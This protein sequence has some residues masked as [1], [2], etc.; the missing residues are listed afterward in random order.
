MPTRHAAR[1]LAL[2]GWALASCSAAVGGADAGA[3][4]DGSAADSRPPTADAEAGDASDDTGTPARGVVHVVLFTHIEDNTPG[5]TLG[6]DPSRASYLR[7]R[8]RLIE[9]AQ[10]ARRYSLEWVLQPDWKFLEAALLYEDA[11]TTA[12]T[13]GENVLVYLRDTLGVAIDPHSHENGGYDYTDVAHLLELLGV[14]GST[15]IGGHIWDP[16]LTQFQAWDRFRVAVP[17]QHY[18]TASWRG[19]I[20]IGAGTPMHV[21]DPLVSGVWRPQD[22]DHFFVDD[23][24]ANIVAVGTWARDAAGVQELVTLYE[25]GTIPPDQ[26][27]TASWNIQP[28]VLTSATGIA[29]VEASVMVPIGALRDA[30]SVVVTD[31][32]TLV[33]TWRTQYGGRSSI[34]QP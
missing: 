29:D 32:T 26:M 20:L 18:P 23:P 6:S 2:C 1:V 28:S 15:V 30:G 13:G 17:G 21:N 8:G 22:R 24:A 14:G 16:S 3:S 10:L 4:I 12:D 5:G 11:V 31:F 7:L 27:L 34:Y 19:D 9:M 33:T 25:D